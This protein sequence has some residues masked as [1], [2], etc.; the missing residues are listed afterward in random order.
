[1]LN[2]GDDSVER[3]WEILGNI[4]STG[5]KSKSETAIERRVGVRRSGEEM[6]R[7]G[8]SS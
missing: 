1:M 5:I 4:N 3:I 8:T 6:I 2:H 7:G